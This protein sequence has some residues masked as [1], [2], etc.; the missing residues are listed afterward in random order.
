MMIII[1]SNN[2]IDSSD[3][4]PEVLQGYIPC[5][6]PSCQRSPPQR[7]VALHSQRFRSLPCLTSL[8]KHDDNLMNQLT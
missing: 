7:L 2:I 8:L 4:K 5:I 3:R 6:G 1:T